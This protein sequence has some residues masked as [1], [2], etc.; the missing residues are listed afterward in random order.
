[1]TREIPEP[2]HRDVPDNQLPGGVGRTGDDPDTTNDDQ[3]EPRETEAAC[4]DDKS[5]NSSLGVGATSSGAANSGSGATK[6]PVGQDR[7]FLG[8]AGSDRTVPQYLLLRHANRHGVIAG[9]TGAGKTISLQLLAEGFSRAGIPVFMGD[10]KGDLAGLA[11]PG[12]LSEA[13]RQRCK[14]IGM[15]PGQPTG[16]PV[17]FWDLLGIAGH[18]VRITLSDLGPLILARLLDLTEAQDGVLN[19]GFRIADE[20]GI[21][22]V[23]LDD[24]RLLLIWMGRN[25]RT[26]TL[27]YG[28]VTTV[29]IGGIQRRLLAFDNQGTSHQFGKPILDF[30][31]LLGTDADGRGRI[32]ILAADQLIRTPKLY[33]M[34][35]LWL[36]AELFERMPEVGDVDQPRLVFFFDEAHLLFRD[37]PRAMVDKLEQVVRLIRSKGVGIYFATQDPGDIPPRIQAQ[38]GNRILHGLRGFT[39]QDARSLKA[40]AGSLRPNPGFDTAPALRDLAIGEAVVS[41]PNARGEPGVVERVMICPPRSRMG[42]IDAR[43]RQAMIEASPLRGKYDKPVSARHDPDRMLAILDNIL[44]QPT[45]IGIGL[46]G[47]ELSSEQNHLIPRSD[48]QTDALNREP[49]PRPPRQQ[50]CEEA[51]SWLRAQSVSEALGRRLARSVGFAMRRERE[52]D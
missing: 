47:G 32:N 37:A 19:I 41:T 18:P 52:R 35:L 28:A 45:R 11:C 10:V 17:V 22:L 3:S 34:F 36:L 46:A 15:Q 51:R 6:V 26:L 50:S 14:E 12:V 29:S 8:G 25:A 7:I 5:G 39:P 44:S 9:A 40:A 38:L 24:L 30:M 42:C 48:A 16:F 49:V 27:T 31:D 21:E 13:D 2:D 20:A 33:A 43:E 23:T 1:M 4:I